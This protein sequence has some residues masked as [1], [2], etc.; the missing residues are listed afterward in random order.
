MLERK[1]RQL[2]KETVWLFLFYSF[3][4]FTRCL[5]SQHIYHQCLK[6]ISFLYFSRDHLQATIR[7]TA[8]GDHLWFGIICGT[9]QW[10]GVAEAPYT[11]HHNQIQK[12]HILSLVDVYNQFFKDYAELFFS[13]N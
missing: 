13:D 3:Y 7:I 5:S 10:T 11:K 9:V 6:S 12:M 8:V 4:C 1:E 2:P